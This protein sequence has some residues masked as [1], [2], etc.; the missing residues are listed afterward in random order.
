MRQRTTHSQL[1]LPSGILLA[2]LFLAMVIAAEAAAPT[3]SPGPR[4]Y[5][6]N[7]S[8]NSVTF[9]DAT[10]LKVVATVDS[11]NKST[12]DLAIS[13]DGRWLYATNMASGKLSVIDT[14]RAETIASIATGGRSHVVA[15]TNDNRHAWVANINDDNLSIVDVQNLRV[16]GTIAVGKGPTGMTFSRDGRHAFVSNQGDRTLQVID[17][18]THRLVKTIPVGNNPHFLVF[19]PDGRIWGCNTGDDDIFVIDTVSLQKVAGIKVGKEPQQVAFAYRGISG[20]NAYV[21][22][23]GTNKVVVVTSDI[24]DM[25]IVDQIDVGQRPNGITANPDGTRLYV[26]HEVSNDLRVIDSGI[27]QVV[28]TVAVG[29]KPIRVIYAK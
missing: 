9:I 17:T 10:T 26:G 15:L 6:A 29:Q 14:R 27:G 21:T 13:R 23:S 4:I 16:V 5:V 1:S 24:K 25:R 7:E 22:V 20:P 19:G 2:A 18:A 11:L 28:S 3:A 12:H 8:S